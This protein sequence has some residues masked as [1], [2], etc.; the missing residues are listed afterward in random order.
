MTDKH[1]IQ[2]PR[3]GNQF[4]EDSALLD[5]LQFFVPKDVLS[6]AKPDL[7]DLGHKVVSECPEY[8]K[9][10]ERRPPELE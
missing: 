6:D 9:D 10:A 2:G 7:V 5:Y 8:A 1:I 4:L 3:L